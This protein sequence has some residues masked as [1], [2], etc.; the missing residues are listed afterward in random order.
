MD[1]DPLGWRRRN[2]I[3]GYVIAMWHLEDLLRAHR[4]DLRAVEETLIPATEQEAKRAALRT[5]Y[6]GLIDQ[7]L[8]EGLR[9]KGHLQEV[10]GIVQELEY[11]HRTLIDVVEDEAHR[12]LLEA[13][14]P[15]LEAL[16]RAG[17][18]Q[19]GPILS[20]FTA[21]YGV[22]LLQAQGKPV[23]DPTAEAEG[24]MRRLLEDLG[25]HYHRIHMLPGV[26]M[27]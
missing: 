15:G 14:T 17:S 1:M 6:S 23:S 21:V 10:Q 24:H 25:R 8:E 3:T 13:A 16:R 9:E 18:V 27:N 12:A 5:W 26:S 22:M 11:L 20:C 2:D 4:F 19:G 7:M